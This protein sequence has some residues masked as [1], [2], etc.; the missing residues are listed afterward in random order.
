MK[1]AGSDS[2]DLLTPLPNEMLLAIL[3]D[4]ET[5]DLVCLSRTCHTFR[6]ISL[7]LYLRRLGILRSSGAYRKIFLVG[8]PA[9]E[10]VAILCSTPLIT[11]LSLL[12]CDLS[13]IIRQ[14]YK[15][16]HFFTNVRSIT[17]V[18]VL[19]YGLEE[20]VARRTG[21]MR[22]P[23]NGP[24]F[25]ALSSFLA[26]FSGCRCFY[27]S[28]EQRLHLGK[29]REVYTPRPRVRRHSLA[30]DSSIRRF[31]SIVCHLDLSVALLDTAQMQK[32]CLQFSGSLSIESL[33]LTDSHDS[34]TPS[35]NFSDFLSRLTLPNLC[36]F[37]IDGHL[38]MDTARFLSRHIRLK[39]INILHPNL[40]EA[41]V[42]PSLPKRVGLSSVISVNL[43]AGF[44]ET[45]FNVFD[46]PTLEKL[47]VWVEARDSSSI[48]GIFSSLISYPHLNG[49]ALEIIFADME[50]EYPQRLNL[51]S[52]SGVQELKVL[53]LEFHD[54]ATIVSI[55]FYNLDRLNGRKP[56]AFLLLLLAYFPSLR[57]LTINDASYRKEATSES[58]HWPCMIANTSQAG[59][60]CQLPDLQK[61]DS[62]WGD[63][64][65]YGGKWCPTTISCK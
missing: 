37:S 23:P 21:R 63:W 47:H 6:Y 17:Q 48:N 8:S 51:P 22:K 49:V 45:F 1:N 62:P 27:F 15:F 50:D 18:R 56:Q 12:E 19:F 43:S 44:V 35:R 3:E 64:S 33:S 65:K 2:I 58:M 57:H 61:I 30:R 54:R 52:L 38:C 20:F 55:F 10:A 25:D 29:P 31:T 36:N 34:R 53:F 39:H 46:F 14:G 28:V 7:N 5:D 24:A 42:V 9:V 13:F 59:Q 32:W 41:P 60:K 16:H 40:G 11:E 4:I 26:S